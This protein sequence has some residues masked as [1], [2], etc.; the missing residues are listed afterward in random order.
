MNHVWSWLFWGSVAAIVYTYLVY[1]L[2]LFLFHLVA[3][4]WDDLGYLIRR[5]SRRVS[6]QEGFSP[7]RLPSVSFLTAAHNEEEVLTRKIGNTLALDY[8]GERMEFLIGSDASSDRTVEIAR[9]AN[10]SRV[11]TFDYSERSGKIGVLK[12]L[13][14][15]AKGEILVFSDANTFFEKDSLSKLIRHFRDPE[16]GVVCGELR[17]TAADGTLQN[18]G[19]YWRFETILKMLES[20]FGAVLGAN[21]GIYAVRRELF[22]EIPGDTIIEDFVIPLL[23]RGKGFRTSFDPEAVALERNPVDPRGEFRR[24]VRI[25]TGCAQAM[26]LIRHLLSPRFGMLSFSLW[27]HKMVRWAVPFA[28]LLALGTN[29]TLLHATSRCPCHPYTA[30]LMLQ[31]LFYALAIVGWLRSRWNKPLWIFGLPFLFVA[32]NAALLIGFIRFWLGLHEVAWKPTAR[33]VGG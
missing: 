27:S 28:L 29:L 3:G 10:D 30:T 11:R 5:R 31:I 4:A 19:A 8:P 1:P 21:G 12:K 23:I 20:R 24:R 33:T 17:L 15:E 16:V 6:D 2:L 22:P 26:P 7:D 9:Q 18:E 13:V 14:P 32:M 25:G